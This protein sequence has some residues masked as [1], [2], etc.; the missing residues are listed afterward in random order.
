MKRTE[1]RTNLV[2]AF[3]GLVD[4]IVMLLSDHLR[5]FRTELR[6]D[7]WIAAKYAAAVLFFGAIL[8]FSYAMLNLSVVFFAGWA[9][10]PLGMAISTLVLTLTN[11]GFSLRAFRTVVLRIEQDQLGP[12]F[13][14]VELTRS[15]EWITPQN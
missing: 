14:S 2:Q 6:R 11:A 3:Q 8:L 5:L 15:K 7:T 9:A 1:D 13:S 4:E 10:G 12:T